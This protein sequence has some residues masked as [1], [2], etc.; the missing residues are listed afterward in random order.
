[1]GLEVLM[2]VV[3]LAIALG[4]LGLA[5]YMYIKNPSLPK[6]LAEKFKLLYQLICNKYFVDEIYDFLFVNPIKRGSEI[7]WTFF[8]VR[9]VDG[10]VNGSGR[11]VEFGSSVLKRIQTGYV[12]NYALSIL[13]GIGAIIGYFLFM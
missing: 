13:V 2:M 1:V 10:M 6:R 3:S 7:L 4:G 8:D 11:F 9:V 12:Q 5:Y